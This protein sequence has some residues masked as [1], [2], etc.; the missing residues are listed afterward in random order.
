M[1]FSDSC[2]RQVQVTASTDRYI[3]T[4][5]G[6]SVQR[7]PSPVL[8]RR[9]EQWTLFE[10]P[11]TALFQVVYPLINLV[12]RHPQTLSGQ[13][14]ISFRCRTFETFSLS[15]ERDPDATDVFE[16]V[17]ELTVANSVTQLYAFYFTPSP[18]LPG[19]DGWTLYSPREEFGR[20]GI[21]TRSK[22]SL[23]R[24]HPVYS[25]RPAQNQR[26][27]VAGW[28]QVPQ[29]GPNTFVQNRFSGNHHLK[30]ASPVF[31]QFLE[32][33]RNI[34][35][36]FPTRFGFN[37]Y[38]LRDLHTPLH[39]CQFGTFLFNSERK[40]R[41]G[42]TGTVSVWDYMNSPPQAEKYV[43]PDYNPALDE[44]T[45]RAPTADQGVFF[46]NP[47]DVRFWHELYG[48]GD[49][50]MNGRYVATPAPLPSLGFIESLEEGPGLPETT[51]PPAPLLSGAPHPAI[52]ILR[53]AGADARA[54]AEPPRSWPTLCA[55]SGSMRSMWDRLSSGAGAAL[56]A[57]QDA[58]SNGCDTRTRSTTGE[59][60]DWGA[61][62][63]PWA[64]SPAL[65]LASASTTPREP[66]G[67]PSPTDLTSSIFPA[68]Q[69]ASKRNVAP[70]LRKQLRIEEPSCYTV[71][72][73]QTIL[74]LFADY[75]KVL[76][77]PASSFTTDA[78]SRPV[79]FVKPFISRT[80]P[81]VFGAGAMR[82]AGLKSITTKH[83][84]LAS[85]LL[86]VGIALIRYMELLVK[87]TVTL[88]KVPLPYFTSAVVGFVMTDVLVAMNPILLEYIKIEF[89]NS[90]GER[91]VNS[92]GYP[93]RLLTDARY[94][95]EKSTTLT[96]TGAPTALLETPVLD[97]RVANARSRPSVP[98]SRRWASPGGG[99]RKAGRIQTG[100]GTSLADTA[101]CGE[102]AR[103]A[104]AASISLTV[105]DANMGG[106]VLKQTD[107]GPDGM[108]RD[109]GAMFDSAAIL[110][111]PWDAIYDDIYTGVARNCPSERE[112]R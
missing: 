20:K 96:A 73:A 82:F 18:P 61:S 86:S 44:P 25:S 100:P 6:H 4:N 39:S 56:S 19:S 21:G 87:E 89:A 16:S 27:Y 93:I 31:H 60:Q 107:G 14:P 95:H 46:S 98:A 45:S 91:T 53:I 55:P 13:C 11:S 77:T 32:V 80:C 106:G 57:V 7:E 37:E 83:L 74:T 71:P 9:L 105:V 42:G 67:M 49:E 99:A 26:L 66:D 109:N 97:K 102:A 34:Q 62:A 72:A 108:P 8:L 76:V 47:K 81:V 51:A 33:V 29:Q 58:Y 35:R 22:A 78:I 112:S 3:D 104:D 103:T 90:R 10:Y 5:N 101:S 68:G 41:E 54:C 63:N 92:L 70:S 110:L 111:L 59:L 12:T 17:K 79:E 40:C 23:Q 94:R 64:T 30:K 1:C 38:F 36:Q 65:H 88:Q 15:F 28:G 52:A 24:I 84:A 69:I 75:L 2:P 43:N 50:E 85:Q 48:R